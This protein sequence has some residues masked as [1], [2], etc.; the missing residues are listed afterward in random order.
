MTD[1]QTT[2]CPKCGSTNRR[3]GTFYTKGVL[4]RI[5]F[6]F[7]Y[8]GLFSRKRTVRATVCRQCGYMELFLIDRQV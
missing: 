1:D 5:A 6:L 3:D 7:D 8:D 4:W 2:K